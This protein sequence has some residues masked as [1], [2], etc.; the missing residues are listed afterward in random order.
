MDSDSIGYIIAMLILLIFSSYFSA[1]ETAFSSV[2]KIRLKNLADNGN[3]RAAKALEI[4]S[5]YDNL[6]S[7][8]LIGNNI[9][10]IALASIATV[11]FVKIFPSNGATLSTIVVTVV[12]LIFGEITPKSIA[13]ELPEKFVMFSAPVIKV[14][15]VL[16]SPLNFLFSRWKTLL[17]KTFKLSSDSSITEEELLTIVDEAEH[18]GGINVQES[19]LIRSAIEFND[20]EAIDIFTPRVD[21]VGVEKNDS[22]ENI[23]NVFRDTEYSRLPV[24]DQT[25]DNI[26]GVIHQ[27]DFFNLV[28]GKNLSIDIIIKPVV[29][30][31]ETIKISELLKLLQKKK[32]HIAVIADEYG[33]TVGIVTME[34]ILEELV[35][36]IW[37]EH[38]EVI[39]EF[40]EISDKKYRVLCSASLEDM[41]EFF[42]IEIGE[43]ELADV[44]TV[45]G[46]VSA[47]LGKIPTEGD[48]FSFENLDVTVTRTDSRRVIEV[49]IKINENISAK[50]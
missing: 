43:D 10:N 19:E 21:I 18:E 36:E 22:N 2:N 39:Q 31:T 6:L 48:M 5:N 27:K 8:I 24:Y 46:W 13:K 32:T 50:I 11:L 34:D 28:S 3:K 9:V 45:G 47:Q 26:I 44:S 17:S 20:L 33:G 4:S 40:V 29:F 1:T 25:I 41:C 23:A 7:T 49:N 15:V 38:D 37:D 42:D 30:V 16:L 12:V 35:G 14:L